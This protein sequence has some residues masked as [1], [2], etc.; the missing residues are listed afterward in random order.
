MMW[1]AQCPQIINSSSIIPVSWQPREMEFHQQLRGAW[2]HGTKFSL[3]K[4][5]LF[6]RLK[7]QAPMIK[8]GL[9]LVLWLKCFSKGNPTKLCFSSLSSFNFIGGVWCPPSASTKAAG[10]RLAVF[11][12]LFLASG[13]APTM[14]QAAP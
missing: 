13:Q 7:F 12:C 14:Q 4:I 9:K 1:C 8:D 2:I 6:E 10:C 5:S 3:T 11:G